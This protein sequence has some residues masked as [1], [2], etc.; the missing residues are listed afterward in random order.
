MALGV[1]NNPLGFAEL[2]SSVPEDS[3]IEEADEPGKVP[4]K[5]VRAT[6]PMPNDSPPCIVKTY[7]QNMK[8]N[9]GVEMV[10]QMGKNAR[11]IEH[12]DQG[13]R[14]IYEG[15]AMEKKLL[16]IS[17]SPRSAVTVG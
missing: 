2:K 8:D 7:L 12:N 13:D 10:S 17:R 1:T 16:K 6:M 15:D 3:E 9:D 14:R 4:F 5:P 11:T